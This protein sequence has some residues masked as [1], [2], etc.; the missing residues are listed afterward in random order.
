[1]KIKNIDKTRYRS[2][3]NKIIIV[4]IVALLLGSIGISQMLI[5]LLSQPDADNFYFNLM[6][7]VLTLVSILMTLSAFKHHPFMTEVYYVWQLKMEINHIN[8]KLRHVEQGIESQQHAAFVIMNF[9]Y[10]A[11]RQLWT[12]DDN[13][14]SI[15]SLTIKEQQLAGLLAQNNLKV[16]T[17]DYKRELLTNY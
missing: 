13:T 12:L 9:F 17:D 10:H 1:M 4:C 11:S 7:V 16:S 14:I 15:D 8:R 2:H 6:G 5:L 3:L